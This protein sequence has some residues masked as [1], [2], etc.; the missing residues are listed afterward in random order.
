MCLGYCSACGA[1]L[2]L[3]SF[4]WGIYNVMSGKTKGDWIGLGYLASKEDIH[5]NTTNRHM[6]T[7]TNPRNSGIYRNRTQNLVVSN[8]VF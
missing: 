1:K 4:F 3:T 7:D 6:V 2:V 8:S 5:A